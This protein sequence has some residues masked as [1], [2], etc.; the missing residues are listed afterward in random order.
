MWA[1][2]DRHLPGGELT[3]DTDGRAFITIQGC[4]VRE[5]TSGITWPLP[6][7]SSS[8]TTGFKNKWDG[9]DRRTNS[10][11]FQCLCVHAQA[12][13]TLCDPTDWS[14]PGSSVHGIFQ[15][16]LL[17]WVAIYY[18]R[19]LPDPGIKPESL[20]LARRFFYHWA[21]REALN[22]EIFAPCFMSLDMFQCLGIYS[23]WELE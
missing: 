9:S 7:G 6:V 10:V 3:R 5:N 18:S 8:S 11:W 21:T 14:P 19:D 1:G 20:V 23:L 16:R 13:P 17:E 4:S 2:F 22:H 15:A 12:C